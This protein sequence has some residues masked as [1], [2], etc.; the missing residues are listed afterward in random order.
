[1]PVLR[2]RRSGRPAGGRSECRRLRTVGIGVV[3]VLLVGIPVWAGSPSGGQVWGAVVAEVSSAAPPSTVNASGLLGIAE[4]TAGS[5]A[6]GTLIDS[7]HPFALSS[8]FFGVNVH[9][10]GF[11]NQSLAA[12]VNSTPFVSFRFSPMG[13]ATNQL[14]SV[15]Y[16]QNG[17][18]SAVYAETDAEFVTWCRWVACRATMM[19]PAEIDNPSEAAATVRYVEQTLGFHPAYWAIGN[20]PQQWTHFGIPWTH[21]RTTDHSTPTPAEYAQEVQRYVTAM[22]AVDPAIRIIG[23]ESVVGGT[24][25]GSWLTDVVRVDGRNLS[26]VA[27]HAYPL[28]SGSG[29]AS[30]TAFYK[31]LTNP[32]AFPM[33]YPVTTAMVRAACPTCHLSVFVDELNAGL[34]GSFTNYLT[35]YPE[36]PFLA[37]VLIA[38]MREDVR[39]VMFFDLEDLDGQQP[40]GLTTVGAGSRPSFLLYSDILDLLASGSVVRTSIR[41]GPGGVYDVL[42]TNTTSTSLFVVNTNL[43]RSLSLS[44]PGNVS[45]FGTALTEYGWS[46]PN[47]LP[48]APVGIDHPGARAWS[49]PPQSLLLLV[50]DRG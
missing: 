42:T 48:S 37:A 38:A 27:Y 16:S 24:L 44:L 28:G 15:T 41:G 17:V 8:Q 18:P 43:T 46:F 22:R 23:I 12:L 5:S 13:E 7:G 20:E 35:H 29:P 25:S 2:E 9:V 3:L 45:V 30:L 11:H 40:Y 6:A 26:A 49:V 10:V 39:R 4:N 14:T 21:W 47:G 1:M 33:N 34:G 31:A 32:T 19:V 50:W 36:V